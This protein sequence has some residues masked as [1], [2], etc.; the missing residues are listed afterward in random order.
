MLRLIVLISALLLAPFAA[1]CEPDKP[2]KLG[3]LDWESGQFITAV[4][5]T[6]LHDGYGCATESVPGTTTALGTLSYWLG[7]KD[8]LQFQYRADT[9]VKNGAK[10][11]GL[12]LRFLHVF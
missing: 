1:A 8:N 6:I 7:K 3:A 5:Q 2:I 12:Q 11:H 10:T 9:E 4:L